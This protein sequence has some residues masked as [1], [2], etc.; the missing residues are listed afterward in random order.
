M[1][2]LIVINYLMP[3][4]LHFREPERWHC[5]A[6]DG[7]CQI[8]ITIITRNKIRPNFF[9]CPKI[10]I[11]DICACDFFSSSFKTKT[12]PWTCYIKSEWLNKGTQSFQDDL[13]KFAKLEGDFQIG[14]ILLGYTFLFYLSRILRTTLIFRWNPKT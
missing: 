12:L 7:I 4:V 2:L 3:L 5:G 6:G 11:N 14:Y 13:K 1:S 9:F 8:I 10:V